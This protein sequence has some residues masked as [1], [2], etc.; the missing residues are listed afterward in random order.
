MSGIQQQVPISQPDA[1]ATLVDAGHTGGDEPVST[2]QTEALELI[3]SFVVAL[4][5]DGQEFRF[6]PDGLGGS[7]SRAEVG[8]HELI[9]PER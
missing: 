2:Q 4:I 7:G 3:R 6:E 9:G 1:V 5:F 8:G